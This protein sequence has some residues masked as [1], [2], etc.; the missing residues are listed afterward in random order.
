MAE[1]KYEVIYSGEAAAAIA[2]IVATRLHATSPPRSLAHLSVA[3]LTTG[4][5][6]ERS[7]VLLFVLDCDAEGAIS[8]DARKLQRELRKLQQAKLQQPP[9]AGRSVALVVGSMY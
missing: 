7:A 9:F 5:P 4:E 6:A 3:D 1:G 8:A 2:T